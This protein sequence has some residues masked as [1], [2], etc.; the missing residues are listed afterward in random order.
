M[1]FFRFTKTKQPRAGAE[2]YAFR[3]SMHNPVFPVFKGPG[4]PTMGS[5]SPVQPPPLYYPASLITVAGLGGLIYNSA[6]FMPLGPNPRA[7]G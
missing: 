3:S 4:V 1:A 2:G 5:I 6:Y 7:R